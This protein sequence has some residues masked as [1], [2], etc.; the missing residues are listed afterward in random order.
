MPW[1]TLLCPQTLPL[2]LLDRKGLGQDYEMAIFTAL[3][4]VIFCVAIFMAIKACVPNEM[5]EQN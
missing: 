3:L 4:L 2:T 1:K 5:P